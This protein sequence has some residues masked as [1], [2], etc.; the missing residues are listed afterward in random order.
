MKKVKLLILV[1]FCCMQTM[2]AAERYN[3]KSFKVVLKL[4][5]KCHGTPFYMAKQK[6]DDEWTD[7]FESDEKLLN[8]HKGKT[9]AVENIEGKRFKYYRSNILK[10]LIDNSKYA[11]TVHA[12]DANFCGPNH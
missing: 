6:D 11:G 2:Q 8:L 3:E 7:Y 10:F 12:C 5:G 4:C 9:E 1:L